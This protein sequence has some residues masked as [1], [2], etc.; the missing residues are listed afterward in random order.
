MLI[1]LSRADAVDMPVLIGARS[2]LF[3]LVVLRMSGSWTAGTVPLR[4]RRCATP[5]PRS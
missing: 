1:Q 4:E 3:V 5:V 2:A